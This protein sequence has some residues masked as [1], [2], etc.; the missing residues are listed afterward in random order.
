MSLRRQRLLFRKYFDVP[1]RETTRRTA[2]SE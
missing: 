1:S 2:T